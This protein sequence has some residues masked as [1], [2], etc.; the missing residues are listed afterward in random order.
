MNRFT[1]N[2]AFVIQQYENIE[3]EAL[4][5]FDNYYKLIFIEDGY[6]FHIING[7]R[8]SY[9]ERD[10]FIIAPGDT[11]HFEIQQKTKF[12]LFNFTEVLFSSK[13]NLP[14]RKFWLQKIEPIINKPNLVSGDLIKHEL[15]RKII[16]DFHHLIVME[17]TAQADYSMHIIANAISSILSILARNISE[18]YANT[19]K[20]SIKSGAKI[21][22][23]IAYIRQHVYDNDLTKISYLS[24]LFH[25]SQ[26][27]IST[28][29][30][31]ETGKSIHQYI[32]QYKMK[33]VDHRLTHTDFTVA[34]IAY[35]L[36]F[37][38]ESHLTKTFKKH[39]NMSPRQY[40]KEAEVLAQARD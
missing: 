34:E 1:L 36:G 3:W 19:E 25:M 31:R 37:T 4:S 28:Y 32:T 5:E 22:D 17:H 24:E 12:T 29:F 13:S 18:L 27:S 40:R 33:L 14:D 35:Q 23:I 30:K 9:K 21:D 16:W 6:G 7:K 26:S 39:F 11:H 20:T 2:D 10:L 38:D 15:D 8:C